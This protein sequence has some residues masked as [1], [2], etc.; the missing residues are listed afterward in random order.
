[1]KRLCPIHTSRLYIYTY[2]HELFPYFHKYNPCDGCRF[3]ADGRTY[4]LRQIYIWVFICQSLLLCCSAV[5]QLILQ[6]RETFKAMRASSSA[7]KE[8]DVLFIVTKTL[9]KTCSHERIGWWYTSCVVL[10]VISLY[11]RHLAL[12]TSLKMHIV[13][14]SNHSK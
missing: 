3:I 10:R 7:C 14:H 11:K 4:V 1:M 6:H 2:I 13:I 12:C 9:R 5:P 8:R